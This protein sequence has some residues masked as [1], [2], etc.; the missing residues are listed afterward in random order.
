MGFSAQEAVVCVLWEKDGGQMEMSCLHE[1]LGGH[2]EQN[3][4][5]SVAFQ[6]A[7]T[8]GCSQSE[9][10]DSLLFCSSMAPKMEI[11][12]TGLVWTD[13]FYQGR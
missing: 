9:I 4:K 11:Q 7:R 2:V 13:I 8:L 5:K 10:S 6:P 3:N 1:L 12:K